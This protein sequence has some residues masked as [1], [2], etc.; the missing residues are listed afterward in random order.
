MMPT[1]ARQVWSA[2][3]VVVFCVAI[4]WFIEWRSAPPEP[5]DIPVE[6]GYGL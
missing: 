6:P 2:L 4:W 1:R 5:P 3:A